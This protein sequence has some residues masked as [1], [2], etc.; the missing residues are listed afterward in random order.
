M[1]GRAAPRRRR[2]ATAAAALVAAAAVLVG[3]GPPPAVAQMG[4]MGGEMGMHGGGVPPQTYPSLMAAPPA[5]PAAR[6]AALREAHRR[7][8]SGLPLLSAGLDEATRALQ[9]GDPQGMREAGERMAEGLNLYRSGLS[10]HLA[11]G[12]GQ[13]PAQAALGWYRGQLGL[14]AAT[15]APMAMDGGGVLW[16]LSWFHLTTMGFLVAFLAG[17]LLIQFV[18]MRRVGGLVQRLATA[19]ARAAP[20]PAPAAAGPP[21]SATSTVPP[22]AGGAA[23]T[24]AAPTA[25][26]PPPATA[27]SPAAA[28]AAAK[29]PW[30]GRLRVAAI[31]SETPDVKTFRLMTPEGGDVPFTFMPG[32]FL[33]FSAEIEGE[34]A[35]R[36][37]TIA[38]SPTRRSY[39]E[40]TVKREAQGLISRHLHDKVAVG[41]LLEVAGPMGVFTFTGAEADSI[42]LISGGVGITPMMSVTRYLTDRS[43]PGDIFFLHGARTPQDLTFREELE[44][45]QKRYAN[46][47]IAATVGR[48]EGTAWMGY[49]GHVS[50]EFIARAVPEIA[51]RRVHICGPP[52][53]MAAVKAVLAELGVPQEQIK[54][55]AFGPARGVAAGTPAPLPVPAPSPGPVPA[56]P[57]AAVP[58]IAT[59]EV[60][61]TRSGKTGPLAPDQSVLEAAE[62]IGV[63]IDYSCRVG[64]CGVC[65]VPLLKG[66]V[67]M[68]VEEGLPPEEKARGIILACQAKSTGNLEV[69]A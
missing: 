37:Y 44:H 58:R 10:T 31:F 42:V 50:K 16:G 11:L 4:G 24:P 48:V 60:Q 6:E 17:T 41:D 8:T 23:P 49:Q 38:S 21:G 29:R 67:T 68:E 61:F 43:F 52:P 32:Q 27:P 7:M 13:A 19:S 18:R 57:A 14:P 62:A 36:S 12:G 3:T 39:V 55:E 34:R 20:A 35:R 9:A 56:A 45:L 33:T 22:A 26:A 28:T 53:M 54:T 15:A 59:A 47:H 69:E 30:S 2:L 46:L 64:I 5:D 63:N 25:P 40:V 66:K 1:T 51:R 65:K